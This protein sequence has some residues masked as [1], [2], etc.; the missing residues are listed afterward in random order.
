M[1][2]QKKGQST[3]EYVLVLTAIVAA[4]ILAATK[5]VKPRVEG[6]MDHVSQQMQNQVE[7]IDF[8]KSGQ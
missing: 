8:S 6:S 1:F 4:I 5:F 7:K 3:L 2:V